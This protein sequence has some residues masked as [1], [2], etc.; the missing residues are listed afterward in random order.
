[1]RKYR[2]YVAILA[3]AGMLLVLGACGASVAAPTPAAS[4]TAEATAVQTAAP[5]ATPAS[6]TL[7]DYA[8]S[9]AG[10]TLAK[11]YDGKDAAVVTYHWTNNSPNTTDFL[12]AFNTQVT[13]NGAACGAVI[14][15]AGDG[16]DVNSQT[17]DVKP[18]ASL[19]VQAAYLMLDA[20]NPI[21][22]SVFESMSEAN[23]A[24][25]QT[26]DIAP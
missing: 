20:T 15:P 7:G 24:V 6:G 10:Y 25:T 18:G 22:V 21:E 17:K 4:P 26:F 2:T 1:M 9:I 19:D 3:A 12:S 23:V 8:V 14:V 16:S 13:Q 5:S 11:T